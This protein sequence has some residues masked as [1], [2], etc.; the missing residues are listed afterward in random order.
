MVMGIV[1]VVTGGEAAEVFEFVEAAF[2]T[3][4]LFVKIF[5]VFVGS[6]EV[7]T[8]RDNNLHAAALNMAAQVFAGVAFVGQ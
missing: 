6:F 3:V 2:D 7:G 5:A 1:A 4:T 8:R